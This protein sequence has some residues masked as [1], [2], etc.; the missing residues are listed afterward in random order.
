MIMEVN[1]LNYDQFN[2]FSISFEEYKQYAIIGDI[3]GGNNALFRILSAFDMTNDEVIL[4]NI[5]LNYD[6]RI[7]YIRRIGIIKEV[8]HNT[9]MKDNVFDE[10][11]Y[12]LRKLNYSEEEIN[13]RINF[14]L[15]YF[16]LNIKDKK[17]NELDYSEK[18]MLVVI[19]AFLHEPK[20][21]LIDDIYSNLKNDDLIRINKLISYLVDEKKITV[22]K[23]MNNFDYVNNNDYIYVMD[24]YEIVKEGLKHDLMLDDKFLNHLNLRIPFMYDLSIKLKMYKLIDKVY[25]KMDEMVN[26]IWN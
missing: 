14:Y 19:L 11:S 22:I 7:K 12:P 5:S 17:I 25:L 18:Q 9:F 15:D 1:N 26:D 4:D 23:F 13:K 10:L 8:N 6:T 20:L 16:K 2:N 21:I 3:K 24:N